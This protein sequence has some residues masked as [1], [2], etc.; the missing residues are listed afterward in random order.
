MKNLARIAD[1]IDHVIRH[2]LD[3]CER[4]LKRHNIDAALVELYDAVR[5]PRELAA[6]LRRLK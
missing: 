5:T 2:E 4:A 6:D 1:D 3:D